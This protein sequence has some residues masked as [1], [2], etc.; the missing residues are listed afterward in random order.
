MGIQ[1]FAA[2]FAVVAC[3]IVFPGPP[4]GYP[5]IASAL[6]V[7]VANDAHL[8]Q[9]F[10]ME[11][12]LTFILVYVIFATAFDTG[13]LQPSE[14]DARGVQLLNMLLPSL[15]SG[16]IQRSQGQGRRQ[17]R[18][19]GRRRQV[20]RKILDDLHHQRNDQSRFRALCDRFYAWI[21]RV[22]WRCCFWR[23][24]QPRSVSFPVGCHLA[25]RP[26]REL[27]CTALQLV[28]LVPRSYLGTGRTSGCT[29]SVTLSEPGWLAGRNT[30]SLTRPCNTAV[31]VPR[32]GK[33]QR[34]SSE[35][36][37][38]PRRRS[39]RTKYRTCRAEDVG[40]LSGRD[41]IVFCDVG[42]RREHIIALSAKCDRLNLR[43]MYCN[44]SRCIAYSRM[45]TSTQSTRRL[46]HESRSGL[47][48]KRDSRCLIVVASAE[49]FFPRRPEKNCVFILSSVRSPDVAEWW[50]WV[51]NA[52]VHQ[53]F[54]RHK[55]F[56]FA[57]T[58]E[59]STTVGE[60]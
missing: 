22:N 9:A 40:K 10:F 37:M 48:G 46:F 18:W 58:V 21:L 32:P 52:V 29:G 42:L 41:A 45:E 8:L 12:I 53:I 30:S 2:I 17:S 14:C 60:T 59:V 28:Y 55:V 54:Q 19:Q 6:R 34:I 7:N 43:Q 27:I 5:N 39:T 15:C 25:M 11:I 33:E 24:I 56:G 23:R 4:T 3:I 20:S 16:H 13:E 26:Q 31:Q 50:T 38:R 36:R 1:L 47:I 35:W 49:D 44:M 51:D 57:E